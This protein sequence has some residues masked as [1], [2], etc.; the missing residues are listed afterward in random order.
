MSVELFW[1]GLIGAA[2]LGLA[3][4][5]AVLLHMGRRDGIKWIQHDPG[6]VLNC[7]LLTPLSVG[8][9]LAH[10]S[11][12]T[13]A[14]G[15][16]ATVAGFPLPYGV[17][18]VA[19]AALAIQD[20]GRTAP[21]PPQLRHYSRANEFDRQARISLRTDPTMGESVY[22]QYSEAF[23]SFS[24]LK[25][26]WTSR[27]SWPARLEFVFN[28]FSA[29]FL[30]FYFMWLCTAMVRK[31]QSD[32]A[33]NLPGL[34]TALLLV[35]VVMVFWVPLRVYSEWYRRFYSDSCIR[36][37]WGFWTLVALGMASFVALG[38]LVAPDDLTETLSMGV[39]VLVGATAV[40][41]RLKPRWFSKVARVVEAMP[42]GNFFLSVGFMATVI[43]LYVYSQIKG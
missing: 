14:P 24:G 15:S 43:G 33:T 42:V 4:P 22:R 2:A 28:I 3:Y 27:G 13:P 11:S 41:A 8:V 40:V 34:R 12:F 21:A 29:A 19:G 16:L 18:L 7:V 23:P 36:N 20:V 35:T 30:S 38:I 31:N 17:L 37:Y 39:G 26:L 9:I 32:F 5:T 1:Y 6:L 25:D 10:S